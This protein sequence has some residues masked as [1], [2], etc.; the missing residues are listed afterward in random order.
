MLEYLELSILLFRDMACQLVGVAPLHVEHLH[1]VGALCVA[2][3][4]CAMDILQSTFS[5]GYC[6]TVLEQTHSTTTVASAVASEKS[7][8]MFVISPTASGVTITSTVAEPQDG[9]LPRSHSTTSE[10]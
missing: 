5:S 1:G 6:S 2:L 9:M 3:A 7:A 10:S 4:L 8:A